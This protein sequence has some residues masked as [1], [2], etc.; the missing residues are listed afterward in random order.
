[1]KKAI[2]AVLVVVFLFSGC[3]TSLGS[4]DDTPIPVRIGD[5]SVETPSG[6][7]GGAVY[8]GTLTYKEE[9]A[10]IN[11]SGGY[12]AY[13][14]NT[15]GYGDRATSN[16]VLV[17]YGSYADENAVKAAIQASGLDAIAD[18]EHAPI[19]IV[20]PQGSTWSAADTTSLLAVAKTLFSDASNQKY[21]KDGKSVDTKST[22]GSIIPGKFPGTISRFLVFADGAAADFAYEYLATGISGPGQ[23]LGE[24]VWKPA[25]MYLS[26]L[27]ST[28]LVHLSVKSNRGLPVYLVNATSQADTAFETLNGSIFPT[29]T[30]TSANKDGFDKSAV[31]IGYDTVLEHWITRDM[32]QGV[33]LLPISDTAAKGLAVFREQFEDVRYYQYMPI[34]AKTAAEGTIP[35]VIVF[36]GIGNTAEYQVWM[37]GWDVLAVEK[38]FV[39]VSVQDHADVPNAKVISLVDSLLEKYPFLDRTRVYASGFSLGGAKTWSL[40]IEYPDRFAG[41]IPC[42]MIHDMMAMEGI[43]PKN[44]LV[45][46]YY[47]GGSDSHINNM[48]FPNPDTSPKLMKYL[49]ETNG[50]TPNFTFDPDYTFTGSFF[51]GDRPKATDWGLAPDSVY[52]FTTADLPNLKTVVSVYESDDGNVYTEFAHSTYAGHE[53]L[54]GGISEGWNFISRFSRKTDGS[55]AINK[56]AN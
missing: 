6:I 43:T 28:N 52:S 13:V 42:N 2:V 45:P 51:I 8:S 34:S 1:M 38:G 20:G 46:V 41:I 22:D 10:N 40:G 48:E 19:I 26:N 29:M 5:T 27:S 55:I 54:R 37:S 31:L 24:S 35:L 50:V 23:F 9:A 21:D 14:P 39:V 44:M 56:N 18:V 7:L 53:P 25:A 3:S 11:Y 30:A 36:H 16:P 33:T 32:G 47:M 4:K 15:A 12:H 49:F 17:L